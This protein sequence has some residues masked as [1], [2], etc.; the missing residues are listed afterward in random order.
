VDRRQPIPGNRYQDRVYAMWTTFNG[1]AGNGKIRL[2][3]SRDRGKTFSKAVTITPPG[4]T[5][6]ATTYT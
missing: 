5:S 6:P 1:S 2:A 4:V 3:V